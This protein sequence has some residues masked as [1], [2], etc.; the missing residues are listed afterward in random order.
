MANVSE[1]RHASRLGLSLLLGLICLAPAWAA[2]WVV[3]ADS[4]TKVA[5]LSAEQLSNIYLGKIAEVSGSGLVVPLDQV[6]TSQL[7]SD[8]HGAVTK[9]NMNQLSAYWAKMMFNGKGEPPKRVAGSDEVKKL[10]KGNPA[11]IGYIEKA[12]VDGS[13]KVLYTPD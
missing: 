8:F 9:K 7:F 2:D 12:K 4:K 13:L 11:M 1:K 5:S 10:L 3:V 6:E